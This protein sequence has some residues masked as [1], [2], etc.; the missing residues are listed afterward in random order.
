[1]EPRPQKF[2]FG[3]FAIVLITVFVLQLPILAPHA[4]NVSYSEFK[5]LVKTGKVA[6]LIL[7]KETISGMLSR[8]GVERPFV[9]ERVEDPGLVA[10]LE[11]ATVKF[12]GRV[13]NT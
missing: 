13:E 3:L 4:A 8:E 10:E 11:R 9:T 7:A 1:M 2:A 6:N 5:A 12:A